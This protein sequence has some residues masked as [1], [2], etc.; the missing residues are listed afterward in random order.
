MRQVLSA[1]AVL[2]LITCFALLATDFWRFFTTQGQD[3]GLRLGSLVGQN[4]RD[5]VANWAALEGSTWGN[6]NRVLL[7]PLVLG[8]PLWAVSL[9]LASALWLL[10]PAREA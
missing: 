10:R 7:Q 4:A 1:L 3:P 8:T 5:A 9:V 6:F 2:A